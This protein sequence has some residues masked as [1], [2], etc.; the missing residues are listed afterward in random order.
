VSRIYQGL[1]GQQLAKEI[2]P[3]AEDGLVEKVLAG[4]S[5]K[6]AKELKGKRLAQSITFIKVKVLSDRVV[7][8]FDRILKIEGMPLVIPTDVTLS[9]IEGR[10][11]RLNPKGIYV[12]GIE[13]HEGAK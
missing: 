2:A 10:S 6:Y 8:H 12:G 1:E 5:Q 9:M 13:E 7:C 4:Q 11:T 3:F